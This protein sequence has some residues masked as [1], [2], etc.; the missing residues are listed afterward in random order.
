V[1]AAALLASEMAGTIGPAGLSGGVAR[2]EDAMVLPA[3]IWRIYAVPVWSAVESAFDGTGERREIPPGAGR[4]RAFNLGLAVEYGVNDWIAVGVQWTPGANLSSSFDFPAGDP[5]HRD[6]ASLDDSFDALAGVKIGIVGSSGDGPRWATGLRKSDWLRFA[7]GL[8]L[9][10]PV[11]A[12]DWEREARSY[13]S[14]GTWLAQTAD[15]HL[16]APVLGLYADLVLLRSRKRELFVD[17]YAQYIPYL[18]TARYAETSLARYLDP[19]LA[20]VRVDYRY[21]LFVEVEPRF[22]AWVWTGVLR[23]GIYLPVRHRFY[24]ATRLDGVDQGNS[25]YRTTVFPT[26]DLMTPLLGFTLEMKVGWQR[27]VAGRN[28]AATDSLVVVLR[29]ML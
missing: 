23:A 8:G 20:G 26:L 9:K 22:D 10:F 3:G 4:I 11:T 14:G 25:G 24:P 16:V 1:A 12:V 6:R 2:A 15:R 29:A 18:A 19:A 21:D 7:V 13:A 28:V 17:V 27:T 5:G